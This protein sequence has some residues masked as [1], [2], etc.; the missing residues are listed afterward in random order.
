MAEIKAITALLQSETLNVNIFNQSTSK[1]FNAVLEQKRKESLASIAH[2][3]ESRLQHESFQS[4]FEQ[5]N[6]EIMRESSSGANA[7]NQTKAVIGLVNQ[8]LW[9]QTFSPAIDENEHNS[10]LPTLG[11]SNDT[12]APILDT[13]LFEPGKLL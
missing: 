8:D 4:R 3:A 6:N 11:D 10:K 2:N 12:E 7:I 5:G 9:R 13:P 1:D